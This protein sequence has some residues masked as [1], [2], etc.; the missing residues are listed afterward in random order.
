MEILTTI[1]TQAGHEAVVEGRIES[2]SPAKR[3]LLERLRQ[4]QPPPARDIAGITPRH[5]RG[6]AP[7]TFNQESLWFLDQLHPRSSLYNLYEAARLRGPLETK[8][9][10][11]ALDALVARHESLRTNFAMREGRPMQIIRPAGSLP[12]PCLV[13]TGATPEQREQ[14][15]LQRLR[16]EA[17]RPFDLTRDPLFRCLLLQSAEQEHVLLLVMH[18][19]ISDGWS[20]GVL[21]QELA[22]LYNDFRRGQPPALA[23]LAIQAGDY[24]VW[25]RRQAASDLF[26]RHLGEWKQRLTGAPALL[27]LPADRPRPARQSF[28]GAQLTVF[29]PRSL[30]ADLKTMGQGE[31][32]TLFMTLLAGFKALLAR[33]TGQT[34]L[35]VGSPVAGRTR[36]ETENLIGFFVNTLALRTDVA[37]DPPFREILGRVRETTLDAF[38]RQDTPFDQLVAELQPERSLRHNP[39]FQVAFAMQ[40]NTDM[41]ARLDGLAVEPLRLGSVTAKFDLFLSLTETAEGLRV[42]A[43]YSADLFDEANIARLLEHYQNLL[44]AAAADPARRLSDLPLSGPAELRTQLL[45]WNDTATDYPRDVSIGQLFERQA[46]RAPESIA[47]QAGDLTMTY[48][49]L[50]RRANQLAHY[51]RAAGVGPDT[52]VGLFVERS[53]LAVIGMLGI[54]KAGGAYLP[55]DTACPAP[56]LALMLDDAR[57]PLL[58]TQEKLRGVIP[59]GAP[60]VICLDTDADLFKRESE[61]NPPCL[62]RPEH[63]AYVMYTSGTTGQPRGVAI[64]QRAINRLVCRT[65]YIDITPADCF[66]QVSN[67]SFDAATFEIWGALLHGARLALIDRD[68]ALAPREFAAQLAAQGVTT[69]FLTTALFNL[70][71]RET[72]EIFRDLTQVLFGGEAAD[73]GAVR[74]ILRHG[75]PRRLL[76]VY[77]PTEST[78]F[79][80]WRL[81]THVPDDAVTV[82]IGR[83]LS[84]TEVYI[85]DPHGAP[86]PPGVAGELCIGGDGL[87]REYLNQSALTA[88]KFVAWGGRKA[89]WRSS[90]V[91]AASGI[92]ASP[93]PPSAIPTPAARRLYRTGDLARFLPDGEIEFIG[94]L[95]HQVKLRGFRIE[96][97]EIEAALLSHTA[98]ASAIVLVREEPGREKR[99]VAYVAGAP[100]DTPSVSVLRAHLARTLPDY[101]IPAAFVFMDA[102]P[103][104]HNGK[105]DRARLPAPA[106]GDLGRDLDRDLD[107]DVNRDVVTPA[108]ETELRLQW[109]W[110]QALGISAPGVTDNFFELGGHS[111]LAVRMFS[112]IEKVFGRRL[113]LA[114]LFQA[115]TIRQLADCLRAGGWRPRWQSLTP[116]QTRGARPPFFCVHAV[117]GNV[118]EYYELA[119]LLAPDQPFY[120][121]QSVGLDGHEAPLTHIADMAARYLRELRELQPAGP[122]YLGGRSFGGMVAYEMARQLQA[123]GERVALLAML[124]TYPLGWMKRLP[125]GARFRVDNAFRLRALARHAVNLWQLPL[126]DKVEYITSK[127]RY[128]SRKYQ[129]L[130]WRMRQRLSPGAPDVFDTVIRRIEELNYLATRQYTPEPYAGE[131]TFFQAT[132]EISADE[133]LTGWRRL[134]GDGVRVV[135]IA[136]DH[137]TMIH[138]PH[139]ASLA[140]QL[141]QCLAEA[142]EREA[143]RE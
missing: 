109:I 142:Q 7:L 90:P 134:A 131:L 2:L 141:R 21:W 6:V 1:E 8:A 39:L 138:A 98:V 103:L 37:G 28:R 85:L 88:E 18:H 101:M 108:D 29:F 4:K 79:A 36:T 126:A 68:I 127:A 69:L 32:A 41:H 136:G 75:P 96:P 130:W 84:N 33:Y 49:E 17:A 19:I 81:V 25:L 12:L 95:D 5:D 76:H 86:A 105:V 71:S 110:E 30:S 9:L 16:E 97:G 27:E 23:P 82:P 50:N 24:A 116:M 45:D 122:Y 22:R 31:G 43:E 59:D 121:L 73:P 137:Q 46:A 3:A 63:L 26:R 139:V 70:L 38:A 74:E 57:A 48:D 72:P 92:C 129:N 58:L 77:G 64:P 87:A 104:T 143:A 80:T 54:L 94:R 120:G 102:L 115:P 93:P 62:T 112:E 53:F 119:R 47:L 133:A 123:A 78:T 35:V 61:E 65:N 117:G 107:R 56:R 44:A 34:D 66:A 55:L 14:D 67:M 132:A 40:Q 60:R 111:L 124:D 11:E 125:P 52:L 106:R 128:R 118:L 83:P 113:P 135:E 89:E 42:T 51:L 13:M 91:S 99:L 140:A 114:T 10:G 100:G 15:L 20:V